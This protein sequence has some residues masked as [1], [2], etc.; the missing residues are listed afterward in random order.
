MIT[1]GSTGPTTLVFTRVDIAAYL[2][3]CDVY[4][5]YG[6]TMLSSTSYLQNIDN[7]TCHNR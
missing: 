3:S 7:N 5:W 4:M 1:A 6:G 2:S